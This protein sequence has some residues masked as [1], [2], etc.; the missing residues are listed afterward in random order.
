M[1][2][3]LLRLTPERFSFSLRYQDYWGPGSSGSGNAIL[4][5]IIDLCAGDWL[6]K[7]GE[8]GM[9][10]GC[11]NFVSPVSCFDSLKVRLLRDWALNYYDLRGFG[12]SRPIPERDRW[13]LE[14]PQLYP[15]ASPAN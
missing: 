6:S 9:T 15:E 5:G 10:K 3:V 11:G 14:E 2:D 4:P 7:L 12:S 13:L 1:R 8:C